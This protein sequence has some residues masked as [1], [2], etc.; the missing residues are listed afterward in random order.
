MGKNNLNLEFCIPLITVVGCLERLLPSCWLLLGECWEE[1]DSS[2]TA[3][4]PGNREALRRSW[5]RASAVLAHRVGWGGGGGPGLGCIAGAVFQG[6]GRKMGV[7]PALG[8]GQWGT[9]TVPMP[10][11][12]QVPVPQEETLRG[13]TRGCL[14]CVSGVCPVMGDHRA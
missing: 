11:G 4:H 8:T 2:L 12:C 13:A 1:A 10:Q 9:A 7:A 6:L 3:H 14:V 5:A